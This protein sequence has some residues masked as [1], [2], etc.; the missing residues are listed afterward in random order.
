MNVNRERFKRK[1]IFMMGLNP[2]TRLRERTFIRWTSGERP[3]LPFHC[4]NKEIRTGS[5]TNEDNEVSRT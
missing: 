3:R 2:S 5:E 1:S 4:L